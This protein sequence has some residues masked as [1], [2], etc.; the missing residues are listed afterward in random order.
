[1]YK[2]LTQDSEIFRQVRQAGKFSFV[3]VFNSRHGVS[4]YQPVISQDVWNR[5]IFGKDIATR[6]EN[7]TNETGTTRGGTSESVPSSGMDPAPFL[8][9]NGTMTVTAQ[10]PV[11]TLPPTQVTS[12]PLQTTSTT[13]SVAPAIT[14][15]IILQAQL[16]F[17]R[18]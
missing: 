12:A 13:K 4:L 2:K 15:G 17:D 5:A 14:S 16:S 11:V 8:S 18:I 3:R 10:S 1:M 6:L 9:L 7:R